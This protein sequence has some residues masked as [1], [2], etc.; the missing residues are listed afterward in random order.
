MKDSRR[1]LLILAAAVGAISVP[2]AKAGAQVRVQQDGR[3]Q[4]A[5]ARVGSGGFNDSIGQSTANMVTPNDIVYGNVTGNRGFRGP[6][7]ERDPRAFTGPIGGRLDDAFIR[8]SS[9]APLPYQPNANDLTPQPYFGSTR[10]VAPPLGSSREGFTGSYTGSGLNPQNP[11]DMSTQ[12]TSAFSDWRTQSLG[13]S[14][15]L[16]TRSGVLAQPGELILQGPLEANNQAVVFTGSPLYGVK[17]YKAGEQASDTSAFSLYGQPASATDPLRTDESTL[18]QM[19]SELQNPLLP[20]QS[21]TDQ[22]NPANA[23]R[24]PAANLNQPLEAPD[25]SGSS[26]N[27][28]ASRGPAA[29]T[30]GTNTNQGLVRRSTLATPGQQMSQYD[31][32]QRRMQR[33]E[34]PQAAT[35]EQSHQFHMDQERQART[36]T[37]TTAHPASQPANRGSSLS[38]NVLEQSARAGVQQP[39]KPMRITSLAAGVRF[40]GLRDLM[41]R[42]E[43]QMKQN[44]FQ[45]AMETYDAAQKVA[46]NNW[47]IRLG[48]ANAELGGGF[49]AQAS[50]D[51]H[52]A[53][54]YAPALMLG[55]Y[56]LNAMMSPQRV[57]YVV[58]ELKD[59]AD[60]NP[61][62]ETP[63]FL[64]AYVAYNTGDEAQAARHLT[65]AEER[66]Q[67]K[68]ALLKLLRQRWYLPDQGATPSNQGPE[69]TDL[70]K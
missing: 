13:V 48:R 9:A 25:N 52:E 6:L 1:R 57:Q 50:D 53:Y 45:T 15:V 3:A 4:D 64:L 31:E 41:T 37:A 70:N 34:N 8:Q 65:Q 21:P 63:V 29:F 47:M 17:Q 66:A 51:I 30:S 56:D 18:R 35:I 27:V 12:Y 36:A 54:A 16:G 24:P 49:Y 39:T 20:Q 62:D 46:P 7:A 26:S 44:K 40:T 69:K 55:Q 68:D 2:L 10:G 43:E 11:L 42:A 32:L 28:N 38:P 58:R 14:E 22:G 5:N 61:K 60:K 59:L 19:R 67:G 33:Y 23:A